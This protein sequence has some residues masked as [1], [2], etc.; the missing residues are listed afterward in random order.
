MSEFSLLPLALSARAQEHKTMGTMFSI[1]T[2]QVPVNDRTLTIVVAYSNTA[3]NALIESGMEIVFKRIAQSAAIAML[4]ATLLSLWLS[5]LMTKPVNT[6]VAGFQAVGGGDLRLR[7]KDD[8]R[9]DEI[10]VMNREFNRMVEKLRE[11]DEMKKDFVAS[12]T[13]ELK[14]PLGAMESYLNLMAY[15]LKESLKDPSLFGPKMPKFLEN[16]DCVKRNSARL[17][18]FIT[19]LLN[20]AKIE[21]AKFEVI[22]EKTALGPIILEVIDLFR[23]KAAADGIRLTLQPSTRTPQPLYIHLDAERVRQVLVNLVSNALKYTPQGGSVT[24]ECDLDLKDPA[25]RPAGAVRV[26]VQDS[27]PG[28]PDHAQDKLFAKFYQVPGARAT[29]KG[30]KGTGLG[31]YIA[32]AIVEAHGGRIFVESREGSGCRFSFELPLGSRETI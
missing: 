16:I 9:A 5:H 14:S 7:L 2:K 15:D 24:V 17:A 27:G 4:C 13:H 22:K 32:K 29:A 21:K 20:A 12:V 23:E 11:V 19:D 28:I 6:L 25:Y 1:L 26:S 18:E 8:S 31:L 10:G 30:P 3:V